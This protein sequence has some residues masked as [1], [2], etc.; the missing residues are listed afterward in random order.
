[1]QAGF[2][3]KKIEQIKKG[4]D[5]I[6]EHGVGESLRRAKTRFPGNKLD[7]SAWFRQNR[8]TA[9]ELMMEKSTYRALPDEERKDVF[10]SFL[11]LVQ[12][13]DIESLERTI[14]SCARQTYGG[15]NIR[16][17]LAPEVDVKTEELIK[18]YC[19]EALE[20]GGLGEYVY[21]IWQGDVIE[22]NS[23]YCIKERLGGLRPEIIYTD[24]DAI[25]KSYKTVYDPLFKPDYSRDYLDEYNY[26]GHSVVFNRDAITGSVLLSEDEIE[27]ENRWNE[28]VYSVATCAKNVMHISSILYHRLEGKLCICER[29]PEKGDAHG[30]PLVSIIIPNKDSEDI[31]R[32][33]VESIRSKSEYDNYEIIIVENNS[34]KEE[35]FDYYKSIEND[36]KIRVIV[37]DGTFN[38]SRICNRGAMYANGEYLLLLN[39][40]TEL[41]EG[42][43]INHMVSLM[44][45]EGV[46]AVGARL[47]FPNDTIQHAGIVVG[48][49]GEAL[50]V[51][52]G[53][54]SKK[55]G[56]MDRLAVTN[57]YSAVT[58]ACMM[59]KKEV[60]DSLGGLDEKFTVAYNDVDLCFRIRE[61]Q[62]RVVYCANSIWYHHESRTRGYENT[63]EKAVRLEEEKNLFTKKWCHIFSAGDPFYNENFEDDI[64]PFKLL[65]FIQ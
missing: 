41:I 62:L 45:K 34:E 38:F 24:E 10:F 55:T 6:K 48:K 43:S 32:R 49:K 57:N 39:N 35:T 7:Y 23:L 29:T 31:L 44:E 16:Y 9:K 4:I 11:L 47:L 33:C 61:R 37:Y 19:G 52:Y 40:D 46:G 42:K 13:N 12:D 26:M 59:V 5:M 50:H 20:E 22:L 3:M 63:P 51:F 36:E 14:M 15:F 65:K 21:P 27:N 18:S 64:A 17:S 25:I 8:A 56:Y 30:Q 58:G 60:Y 1:M 2:C 54:R 53:E 28:L